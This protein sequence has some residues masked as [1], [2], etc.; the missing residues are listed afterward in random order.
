MVVPETLAH[1]DD[2]RGDVALGHVG[3]ALVPVRDLEAVGQVHAGVV[4]GDEHP[5]LVQPGLGALGVQQ[6]LE[7]LPPEGF[8][9]VVQAGGLDDLG[10]EGVG[11]ERGEVHLG[12][13]HDGILMSSRRTPSGSVQ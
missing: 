8:A 5:D 3:V 2:R 9:E 7:A 1:H 4:G 12:G 6:A 11:V 10:D 13:A